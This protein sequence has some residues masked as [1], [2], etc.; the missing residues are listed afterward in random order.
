V[1]FQPETLARQRTLEP[2][3]VNAG[4]GKGCKPHLITRQKY[5]VSLIQ[6]N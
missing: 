3:P 1:A 6:K 5:R 2:D 4:V